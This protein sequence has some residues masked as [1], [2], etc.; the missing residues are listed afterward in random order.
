MAFRSAGKVAA[1]NQGGATVRCTPFK[2]RPTRQAAGRPDS[3]WSR[4]GSGRWRGR[5]RKA[6]EGEQGPR[7]KW[8]QLRASE[9]AGREDLGM[10]AD[11][12]SR[13]NNAS[14][15]CGAAVLVRRVVDGAG[16]E[17]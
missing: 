10:V 5:A 9:T 6:C 12:S 11:G 16:W 13:E 3:R 2:A 7:R 15:R 8:N 14:A 4:S 17:G 1:G